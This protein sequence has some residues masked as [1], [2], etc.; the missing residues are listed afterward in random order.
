MLSSRNDAS[1]NALGSNGIFDSHNIEVVHAGD[2]SRGNHRLKI[3]YEIPKIP[4]KRMKIMY[5]ILRIPYRFLTSG[6]LQVAP[7]DLKKKNA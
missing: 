3:A 2:F 1:Q 4:L 5:E 6:I 7:R